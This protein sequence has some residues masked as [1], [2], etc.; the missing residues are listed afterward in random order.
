MRTARSPGRRHTP[1][2][3]AHIAARIDLR[4]DAEHARVE[5]LAPLDLHDHVA[6]DRPPLLA[7]ELGLRLGQFLGER[8]GVRREATVVVRGQV[9]H[10]AVGHERASSGKDRLVC[11]RLPLHG[12]EDLH[13]VDDPLEHLGE[14]PF[15]K[16]FQSLLKALQ[17]T[18]SKPFRSRLAGTARAC[19]R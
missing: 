10:V 2:A 8:G 11:L 5:A 12:I 6:I 13:W 3:P 4:G 1:P 17:H 19:V 15:H 7:D 9:D 18:H 14:G 16:A